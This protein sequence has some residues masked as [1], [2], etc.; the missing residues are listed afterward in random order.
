MNREHI[1]EHRTVGMKRIRIIAVILTGVFATCLFW[2]LR[3]SST[4]ASRITPIEAVVEHDH[5]ISAPESDSSTVGRIATATGAASRGGSRA[6]DYRM[7]R[8]ML[9]AA[10]KERDAVTAVQRGRDPFYDQLLLM[11]VRDYAREERFRSRLMA[12]FGDDQDTLVGEVMCSEKFCR[13]E[14]RGVGRIDVRERWQPL[15]TRA[16]EPRGLKFFVIANDDDGN[17]ITNYYFGLDKSWTVPDFYALGLLPAR[18]A[19]RHP[20]P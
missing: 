18:H 8:Q 5:H 11:Q 14:L 4:D 7:F 17:T 15:I 12:V 3:R 16:V 10:D 13:L 20:L 6:F 1:G 2:I 19:E 9:S